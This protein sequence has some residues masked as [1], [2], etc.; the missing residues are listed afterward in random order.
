LRVSTRSGFVP[1]LEK[2]CTSS[3]YF[4]RDDSGRVLDHLLSPCLEFRVAAIF[5]Y[6][7]IPSGSLAYWTFVHCSRIAFS[8]LG[9]NTEIFR[10]SNLPL[11]FRM[12]D[13]SLYCA[14]AGGLIVLVYCFDRLEKD[15]FWSDSIKLSNAFVW[16]NKPRRWMISG[17]KSCE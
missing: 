14:T 17:P 10:E 16:W 1:V 15:P 11:N 7:S 5:V 9:V 2:C 6:M 3:W 13:L 12:S 4:S 8:L